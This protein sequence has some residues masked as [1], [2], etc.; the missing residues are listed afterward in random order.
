MVLIQRTLERVGWSTA[1]T[2][3]LLPSAEIAHQ[4]IAF[5]LVLPA[6]PDLPRYHEETGGNGEASNTNYNSDD[7]CL[8]LGGHT[9]GFVGSR[10]VLHSASGR[11]AGCRGCRVC[12]R[13]WH[14]TYD[15]G[16]DNYLGGCR[17]SDRGW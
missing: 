6:S 17:V 4:L 1:R 11:G 2:A 8:S 10:A 12:G 16:L 3:L 7:G 13:D 9:G 5:V 14:S 15:A